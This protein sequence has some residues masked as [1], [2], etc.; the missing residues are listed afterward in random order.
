[1]LQV[2]WLY[3]AVYNGLAFLSVLGTLVI[4]RSSDKFSGNVVGYTSLTAKWSKSQPV[5]QGDAQSSVL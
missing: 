2:R 1:M 5:A 3:M 4:A